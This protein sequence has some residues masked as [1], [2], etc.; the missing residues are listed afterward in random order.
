MPRSAA[1]AEEWFAL[2]KIGNLLFH[3]GSLV[4]GYWL[5]QL[6]VVQCILVTVFLPFFYALCPLLSALCPDIFLN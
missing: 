2:L 1:L 6:P 4:S 5:C 3:I